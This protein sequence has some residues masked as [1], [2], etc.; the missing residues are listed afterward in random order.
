MI[1]FKELIEKVNKAHAME[2]PFVIYRKPGSKTISCWI[3]KDSKVQYMDNYKEGGFVM[4]PFLH[5]QKPVL[6]SDE[7]AEI[8]TCLDES[9]I[10][11][12]REISNS[13]FGFKGLEQDKIRHL[14]LIDEGIKAI[15]ENQFLKVVLTR[16]EV[17]ELDEFDLV[18]IYKKLLLKY[19]GAFAYVWYHPKIG[20]WIGASPET[21]IIAKGDKFRT[22][23]LAG[24]KSFSKKNEIVWGEKEIQEQQIVTDHIAKELAGVKI[25]VG[26][27]YNKNAG[28]LVH[29]CTDIKGKLTEGQDLNTLINALHPTAAVCGLPKN[30]AVEFISAHEDYDRGFYTGFLGEINYVDAGEG[31]DDTDELP[32]T[33]LFVNLR[34]MQISSDPKPRATLYIGGGITKGS[35]PESEW[36]ETVAKSKVMKAV[37]YS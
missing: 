3:Q 4:A 26:Q 13:E 8:Y 35:V 18:P 12:E 32:E 16:E 1:F 24:T 9:G 31:R 11:K 20:L 23:A 2:L 17:N 14:H 36:E 5:A 29:I 19:P 6:F 7:N 33:N 10:T 27:P 28:N 25:E 15:K 37:L 30:K 22:M 21:L 34:C